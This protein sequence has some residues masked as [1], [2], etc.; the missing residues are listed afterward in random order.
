ML[1]Y[2]VDFFFLADSYRVALLLHD[3]VDA[4]CNRLD[5]L[6]SPKKGVWT[7]QR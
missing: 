7:P 1:P 3:R 6:R 5:M 4:L 2:M